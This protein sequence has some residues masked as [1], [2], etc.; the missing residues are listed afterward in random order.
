MSF[1]FSLGD[2]AAL[3]ALTKK[4]YSAWRDA[5]KE[6]ADVVQTLRES[7]TLLCRVERR[8]DTFTRTEGKRKDIE[9]SLEG[10]RETIG[11]LRSVVRDRRRLSHWDRIRLGS[12]RV[13]D[14]KNRLARHLG[15]LTPLL[16][17]L[18][19]ESMGKDI[20][21]L[22][23]TLDR[24]PQVLLNALPAALGKMIDKRMDDSQTARGSIMTTYGDDD[25]KQAYRELRRNLKSFGIK[26]SVV[27]QQRAKLVEFIKTLT[28]DD[29]DTMAADA[30][31]HRQVSEQQ[32]VPITLPTLVSQVVSATEDAETVCAKKTS[33]TSYRQYQAYVETEDEDDPPDNVVTES[34]NDNNTTD[35]GRAE[36]GLEDSGHLAHL[37]DHIGDGA[38]IEPEATRDAHAP[39]C[40]RG[41]TTDAARRRK[42]QAYAE[43]EDED[44]VLKTPMTDF[45][46]L[47]IPPV[48]SESSQLPRKSEKQQRYSTPGGLDHAT[49][50]A[51]PDVKPD[52][53]SRA[54]GPAPPQRT[55]A[56]PRQADS[57]GKADR[58]PWKLQ[59]C[60]APKPASS[61]IAVCGD[62]EYQKCLDLESDSD[63]ADSVAT[64]ASYDG[65]CSSFGQ[66]SDSEGDESWGHLNGGGSRQW[67]D[68]KRRFGADVDDEASRIAHS[69]STDEEDER[70]RRSNQK[71]NPPKPNTKPKPTQRSEKVASPPPP[72]PPIPNAQENAPSPRPSPRPRPLSQIAHT[73]LDVNQEG[74][75]TIQLQTPTGYSIHVDKSGKA[76]SRHQD[77]P[78]L[79]PD[80][81][82][83]FPR[84]PFP[85]RGGRCGC[86]VVYWT[87]ELQGRN[88]RFVDQLRQWVVQANSRDAPSYAGAEA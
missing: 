66:Q 21:S 50:H 12:S 59:P 74:L 26:D 78:G 77:A 42:Y 57:E 10:C 70:P 15:M 38:R 41:S 51:N 85:K 63:S 79:Y 2:L 3:V 14:C 64:H 18:E 67:S 68:S 58:D 80:C 81:F 29:H 53:T 87:P 11:E 82:H 62:L 6:Y 56:T 47:P 65:Y 40:H 35:L 20:S 28:H 24:L 32:S 86:Q 16:F 55:S 45:V 25:D 76:R 1:G 52:C 8:F 31:V 36:R 22:P 19:L 30:H 46:D 43:S 49:P 44:G 69:G 48:F 5:P 84:A 37:G 83:G 4:T 73:A 39:P 23:A 88:P 33:T 17:S 75:L 72:N 13:N 27:R 71:P 34:S 9:D 54:R 7:K 61:I 60:Q